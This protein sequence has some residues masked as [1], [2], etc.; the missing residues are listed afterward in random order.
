MPTKVRVNLAN[1]DELQELP[2]IGPQQASAIVAF[3]TAH[4]PITS[5]RE[6]ETVL[7]GAKLADSA[8]ERVDFAPAE[9]TAP[10]APGA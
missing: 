3:R 10:E 6:L 7:G 9:P 8:W 5:A 1:P 2:G 4:G